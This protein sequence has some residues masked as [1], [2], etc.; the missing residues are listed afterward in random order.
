MYLTQRQQQ[1]SAGLLATFTF[2][3]VVGEQVEAGVIDC[4]FA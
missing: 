2:I 3:C 1:L 4:R